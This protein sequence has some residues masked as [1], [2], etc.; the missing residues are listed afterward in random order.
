[1]RYRNILTSDNHTIEALQFCNS[2]IAKY[3]AIVLLDKPDIALSRCLSI[4]TACHRGITQSQS[5]P[6]KKNRDADELAARITEAAGQPAGIR[7]TAASMAV[8]PTPDAPLPKNAPAN[9]RSRKKAKPADVDTIPISL[10]PN[11]A[12]LNRYILKASER[13]RETGRV[14]SAQ[15]IMIE[16][17]ERG[18]A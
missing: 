7:S 1:L 10:R 2:V 5:E 15:E 9:G 14:V 18:D 11:R 16:V 3:R 6:M 4:V 17:L 8:A 13:T 12:L